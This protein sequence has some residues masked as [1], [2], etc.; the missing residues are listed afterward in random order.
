VSIE[1]TGEG[2]K[3]WADI[4]GR[5]A[6]QQ[7]QL[8]I[9]LDQRVES[10]P[11]V[12]EAITDGKAVISGQFTETD[13]KDLALVLRT[14]AL[15]IELE[16]SQVQRVSATL[17]TSSLRAGLVAGAIGLALVAVYM[18]A[19]YRLLGVITLLGLGLFGALI[20][21]LMG[22]ISQYRGFSLTLA[23]IAGLI[24]SLGIAADSYI[25]YFERVKDELKEGKTFRSAVERA[26]RS[27]L[28]TN[29][30]ANTVAFSAAIILYLLAVGPVRGFAL[31]LGISV[32]LDVGLLYFFT[33]PIVALIAR[34]RTSSGLGRVGMSEASTVPVGGG[35]S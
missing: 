31:T 12:Q 19:F 11:T 5:L 26:F 30:A 22:A 34:N 18:L 17:G 13:A 32:L 4:T 15:P 1:M 7:R 16:R 6:G 27:A 33:H 21:G 3:K 2:T 28:R 10:A 25:I 9:V 14:G 35:G 29:L 24:V 23:G 20:M 8:A